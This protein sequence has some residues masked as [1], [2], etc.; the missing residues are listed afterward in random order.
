MPS[1]PH[2]CSSFFFSSFPPPLP[3]SF[4]FIL[5][6][7]TSSS[8]SS[9]TPLPHHHQ[10]CIPAVLPAARRYSSRALSSSQLISLPNF[11][12]TSLFIHQLFS[13]AHL[14]K[15]YPHLSPTLPPRFH[16]PH[17]FPALFSG[18]HSCA[19]G[20][21]CGT[22]LEAAAPQRLHVFTCLFFTQPAEK[23]ATKVPATCGAG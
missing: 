20:R 6:P 5:I 1:T 13:F 22:N 11:A 14:C 23:G 8:F 15:R 7:P 12:P 16:H 10:L 18:A 9:F 4:L 19:L 2:V 17:L 21:R 3:P